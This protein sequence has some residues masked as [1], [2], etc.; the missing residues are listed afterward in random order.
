MKPLYIIILI[1]LITGGCAKTLQELAPFPCVFA[2]GPD[3]SYDS[4]CPEGFGC[5][6][7]VG[8]V[9]STCRPFEADCPASQSCKVAVVSFDS[10]GSQQ[11]DGPFACMSDG[12]GAA[13]T[14]DSEGGGELGDEC[15]GA[16]DCEADAVCDR[17]GGG[18]GDGV[19]SFR[20]K[21]LC[22]GDEHPC[23]SIGPCSFSTADDE[24]GLCDR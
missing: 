5:V 3:K 24:F 6:A 8:C 12:D 16:I 19:F 23:D 17:S 7:D 2:D 22:D 4:V 20:C 21:A 11:T 14:V 1:S 10:R 15:S 13:S 9:A 18:G